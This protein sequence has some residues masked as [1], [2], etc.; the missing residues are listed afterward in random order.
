MVE[1]VTVFPL[2]MAPVAFKVTPVS[3]I[4]ACVPRLPENVLFAVNATV[5]VD[6]PATLVK[7]IAVFLPILIV[8][9]SLALLLI[10]KLFALVFVNA[11]I[12]S[13]VLLFST[14]RLLVNVTVVADV[15]GNLPVNAPPASVMLTVP[16]VSPIKL[17]SAS[18][19]L[20]HAVTVVVP[21]P[22]VVFPLNLAAGEDKVAPAPIVYVLPVVNA[23]PVT[24]NVNVLPL[25]VQDP[26]GNVPVKVTSAPVST[27]NVPDAVIPAKTAAVVE[28]NAVAVTFPAPS[29]DLPV[30]IAAAEDKVAP[31][32]IVYV[33]PAVNALL[34]TVN[35]CVLPLSVESTAGNV[36]V[37][38]TSLP[39]LTVTVP[40]LVIP[41][42]ALAN[43]SLNAVT[44]TLPVPAI[45]FPFNLAAVADNALSPL[46]VYVLP[47]V[48]ASEVTVYVL[49]PLNV[50]LVA[51]KL[52]VNVKSAPVLT[53]TVP[54]AVIPAK[55]ASAV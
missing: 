33:L 8:V 11:F 3:T 38:V 25:R 2:N 12:E 52:P 24:V 39:V 32:P 46:N 50:L 55:T 34:V 10:V 54:V 7:S 53:V 40:V 22:P 20:L 14:V 41:T 30:N 18:N 19:V 37:K 51:G 45:V 43:V 47:V 21:A 1:L 44:V 17:K 23:S 9:V 15:F 16:F 6:V 48:N 4:V 27:V 49:L 35:V 26:A 5:L 31:A 28:C 42:K 29:N 36:P 13:I